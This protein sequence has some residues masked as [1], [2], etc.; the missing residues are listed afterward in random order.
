MRSRFYLL[1][2]MV[3]LVL[4]AR[5]GLEAQSVA[6][7]SEERRW[8]FVTSVGMPIGGPADRLEEAMRASEW[9]GTGLGGLEY[10]FSLD[11]SPSWT[12]SLRRILS[13]HLDV[14]LIA[15][16]A[17]DG[18]T[19]GLLSRGIAFGPHLLLDHAVTTFS[20]IASF[21]TGGWHIG[22]GPTANHVRI[23]VA[24][25]V[26]GLRTEE[27]SLGLVADSGITLPRRSRIF[28]EGRGQYRWVPGAAVGPYTSPGTSPDDAPVTV[29]EL[30]LELSHVFLSLG[31][32]ARF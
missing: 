19:H 12:V 17:V 22:A 31:L 10:P 26:E 8:E 20:P 29:P 7:D 4:C 28:F 23:E 32:G 30:E 5:D 24:G 25:P 18:G 1:M 9:D 2:G 16:R 15:S 27:W 3:A 6:A 13:S 21:R 14:E 11:P